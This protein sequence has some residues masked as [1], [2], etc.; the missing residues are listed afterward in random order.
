[1]TRAVKSPPKLCFGAT[2]LRFPSAAASAPPGFAELQPTLS[3]K[4]FTT[5]ICAKNGTKD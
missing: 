4:H 2:P 1:M 5:V 3:A